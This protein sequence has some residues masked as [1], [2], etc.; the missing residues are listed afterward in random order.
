M[1]IFW[2]LRDKILYPNS[3]LQQYRIH[4]SLGMG[5]YGITYHATDMRTGNE[6]V[7]KQ[8]RRRKHSR[9]G[10]RSYHKEIEMLKD[11][12]HPSL[13]NYIESFTYQ[14]QYYL[15]M[16][17]VSG[18]SIEE[19]LFQENVVFSKVQCFELMK[20]VMTIV[21]HLHNCGM[22]HRDLR[23]P[24]IIL[25]GNNVGIIDFGLAR[26]LYE[27]REK[28][29]RTS[30]MRE[31]HP[32]S[33][34]YALGHT[35]LFLLYS[36]YEPSTKKKKSWEEELDLSDYEKSFIRKLLQIDPP[37]HSASEILH[38]LENILSSCSNSA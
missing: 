17:K 2:V 22:V 27:K 3:I 6:V 29:K 7:I 18:K 14:N 10:I 33:D 19:L 38:S 4:S 37:F 24:N 8:L 28:K 12:S 26:F 5:S 25:D 11:L 30:L 32:R 20:K 35:L 36:G 21:N 23:P 15:V 16:E 9:I 34:F 1:N 31:I 13:P